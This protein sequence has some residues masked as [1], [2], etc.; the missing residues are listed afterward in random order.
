[1][2]TILHIKSQLEE[3]LDDLDGGAMTMEM[4][5]KE[6]PEDVAEVIQLMAEIAG[7][8][9][10]NVRNFM[11]GWDFVEDCRRGREKEAA[12]AESGAGA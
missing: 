2:T 3:L 9:L 5:D 8:L 7:D 1:M 12:G 11:S 10:I 6:K 4:L